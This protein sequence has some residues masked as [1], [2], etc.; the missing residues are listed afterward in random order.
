M[1]QNLSNQ[2]DRKVA[3]RGDATDAMQIPDCMKKIARSKVSKKI[4]NI[5]WSVRQWGVGW[6]GG[7]REG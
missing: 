1:A 4:A 3:H 7:D 6:C 2:S 5:G